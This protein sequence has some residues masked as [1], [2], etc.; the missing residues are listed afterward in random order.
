MHLS[1]LP[2]LFLNSD[3]Q[4]RIE[5]IQDFE[6]PTVCTSI[7]VSRDGHFILAAGKV[8]SQQK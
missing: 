1:T 7:K 3:I 2:L 4:R 6:M 5:L 8:S